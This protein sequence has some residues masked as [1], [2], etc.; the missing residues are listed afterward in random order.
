MTKKAFD[1]IM[2][3][4]KDALAYVKGERTGAVVHHA[5]VGKTKEKPNPS[6]GR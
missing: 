6:R 5:P 2:A 1:K 4:H 3:G